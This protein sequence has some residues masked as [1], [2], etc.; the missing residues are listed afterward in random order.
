MVEVVAVMVETQPEMDGTA[1]GVVVDGVLVGVV[2]GRSVGGFVM[3]LDGP[4]IILK[5]G[6]TRHPEERYFKAG[7]TFSSKI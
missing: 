4:H 5:D 1:D 2:D 6:R 3:V 7:D